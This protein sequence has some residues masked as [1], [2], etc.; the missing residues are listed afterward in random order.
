MVVFLSA[1]SGLIILLLALIYWK[2]KSLKNENKILYESVRQV[3]E[4][5][6][7]LQTYMEMI[8]QQRHFAKENS[9]YEEKDAPNRNENN[10]KKSNEDVFKLEQ[11]LEFYKEI[12][13]NYIF[14]AN[15][16]EFANQYKA[17]T[18]LQRKHINESQEIKDA[19]GKEVFWEGKIDEIRINLDESKINL[20]ARLAADVNGINTFFYVSFKTDEN[21][22]LLKYQTD[23]NLKVKGKFNGMDDFGNWIVKEAVVYESSNDVK[24]QEEHVEEKTRNMQ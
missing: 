23:M 13:A 17:L 5:L 19:I 1:S 21:E 11:Q 2:R 7:E 9:K 22:K 18:E 24:K 3:K 20:Y 14:S 8:E 12:V 4:T 16:V 15:F 10:Q 6:E